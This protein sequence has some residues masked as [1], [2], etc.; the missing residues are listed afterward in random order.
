MVL[1]LLK[2]NKRDTRYAD[3]GSGDL[4]FARRLSELTEAPVYAVDVHYGTP[5]VDGPIRICTDLDQVPAGA[6]DCAVLMDVLEHVGDDVGL[7]EASARVLSPS[8]KMLVTV[9]AH[10]F[11]WS[12]HDVFLGHHRRY[13]R[14]GLRAVL[15]RGGLDV[16]ESFY[17]YAGPFLVRALAVALAKA[18]IGGPKARAVASW[19][20]PAQHPMTRTARA[21]LNGDFKLSRLL[22][23]TGLSGCGLSIC[24]VC[25]RRSA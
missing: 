23:D 16:A 7:V 4:Y 10:S 8:G 25:R 24:A 11:L 17:F 6:I 12:E 14:A 15:S 19:S 9:P 5:G 18:G 21:V 22:G 20:Y 13:D 2:G 3:I 1:D